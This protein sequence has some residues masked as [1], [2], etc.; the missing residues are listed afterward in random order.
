VGPVRWL[1]PLAAGLAAGASAWLAGT[2]AGSLRGAWLG[3]LLFA[4]WLDAY[5]F[6]AALRPDGLHAF[7]AVGAF[8]A[9]HAWRRSERAGAGLLAAALWA[10]AQALRPTFVA[11]PLILPAL[12]WKRPAS[13]RYR[14]ASLGLWLATLAV[15]AFLVGT[16]LA[17][18]GVAVPSY[19]LG[20]NLACYAVPRLQEER[21]EGE[22]HALRA[23]CKRR[24]R[25]LPPAVRLPA[26]RAY[27]R[28]VLLERP[29]ETLASFLRE[30]RVQTFHSLQLFDVESRRSPY[31]GGGE[32]GT[33]LVAL[34]WLCGAAGLA[35]AARREPGL[36]LFLGLAFALVML[37][38]TTSHLPGSRLRFPVD[39][40]FLPLVASAWGRGLSQLAERGGFRPRARRAAKSPVPPCEGG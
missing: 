32:T 8:A 40:F 4:L 10:A 6:S 38:A 24:F 2:L 1:G 31:P 36:A 5:R 9:S 23:A 3:A 26:Q 15:P 11:L 18:H 20:V 21:G 29:G 37:P 19:V 25:G 27:A 34:F 30:L 22:F 33:A 17:R 7:L 12:L 35:G 28:E 39:L 13:R 16:N 14:G